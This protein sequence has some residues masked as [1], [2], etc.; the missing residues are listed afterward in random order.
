MRRPRHREMRAFFSRLLSA[1]S[2]GLFS[3]L[4]LA[5]GHLGPPSP[6]L[7]ASLLLGSP[8]VLPSSLSPSRPRAC[9]GLG[10]RQATF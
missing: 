8:G 1:E 3:P 2:P 10:T 5:W 9:L 4:A 6:A 7:P